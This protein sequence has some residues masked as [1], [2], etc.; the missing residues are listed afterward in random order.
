MKKIVIGIC[1]IAMAIAFAACGQTGGGAAEAP[2]TAEA[3]AAAEAPAPAAA[4]APAAEA[5]AAPGA[6]GSLEFWTM[7]TGADGINMD[8]IVAE[9]NATNPDFTVNHRPMPAEDLYIN[10]PLAVL[11]GE[12]VPDIALNHIERMRVFAENGLITDLAPYL[13]QYGIASFDYNPRAW[14]MASFDG[15]H[16]GIPLDV[17]SFVMYVNMDLYE[18]YGNGELD[19]GIVTWDEIIDAAPRLVEAGLVPFPITWA[20]AIFLSMY[21]QLNGSLS[22]DGMNP[23]FDN[24]DAL[25]VFEHWQ[26]L[27]NNGWTI[28]EGDA[29]WEMFL[30][31][32]AMWVPE[33]IWMYNHTVQGGLNVRMVNFPVWNPNVKGNWTSSH[34]FVVPTADR[35]D[36]R[37][38]GIFEFIDFVGNNSIEWARAGQVPAHVSIMDHPEFNDMP[39]AFLAGYDSELAMY[40]FRHYGHAVEALDAVFFEVLFGRM[41]PEEALAQAVREARDRIEMAG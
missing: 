26:M 31:G 13:G 41:T 40:D 1:V 11:S 2:V 27:Y 33:G 25:A 19:D 15:G 18:I 20:R 28:R 36:A 14:N 39:Q 37:I 16:W 5:D 7:L 23:D 34:Q 32:H 6:L 12:G 3:P 17:H 8:A 29:P 24:A 30:G 10:F 4:E 22:T 21:G 9:F 38:A 35:D